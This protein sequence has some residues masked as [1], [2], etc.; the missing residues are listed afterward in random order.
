MRSRSPSTTSLP[1]SAAPFSRAPGFLWPTEA[2]VKL[3][4]RREV[5][6]VVSDG[7]ATGLATGHRARRAATQPRRDTCGLLD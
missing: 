6:D 3:P 1:N 4:A 5:L 2:S 7:P